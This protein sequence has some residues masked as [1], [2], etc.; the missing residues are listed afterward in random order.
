[1]AYN[2]KKEYGLQPRGKRVYF[3]QMIS[4]NHWI[5][6]INFFGFAETVQSC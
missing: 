4:T 2:F 6:V 1:M 5:V 3:T